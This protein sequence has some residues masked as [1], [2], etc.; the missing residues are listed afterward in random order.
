VYYQDSGLTQVPYDYYLITNRNTHTV[1]A[2][3]YVSPILLGLNTNIYYAGFSWITNA[4]FYDWREGWNG[5][6]GPPKTVQAVQ[7][8]M[9]MLNRWL[10]N[11]V[12]ANN[13]FTFDLVHVVDTGSH[14]ASI[15]VY[16]SVPLS[17]SVLPAV[18]VTNGGQL[19]NPGGST[20]GMTVATP[21]P[22]YVW[23]NYNCTNN[24][25]SG[26]GS[27]NTA[28]T[29]LP[30]ALMGDSIT[31]LSPNWSDPNSI[32]KFIGG[33]SA[34][35]TTVNAA[36]VA[37]IVPSNP[38]TNG[39]YSGGVENVMRSLE[40]WTGSTLT[41][42]GSVVVPFYS[43]YATNSWQQ[44]GNYY[45]APHRN[46]SFDSNFSDFKLPPLTPFVEYHSNP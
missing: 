40:D 42:N 26:L 30:A 28:T 25:I 6:N 7:I 23:K 37:G 11:M 4:L 19:P 27:S 32:Y 3:N 45:N 39:N 36:I 33:S 12:A 17:S 9:N 22:I 21:F 24:G 29:T 31:I 18:R 15:Y 41:Y 14:I 38:N 35:D 5:G 34:S 46:W 2:T 1:F 8:D 16:N 10:T 20:K 13:G 43:Q 44:T